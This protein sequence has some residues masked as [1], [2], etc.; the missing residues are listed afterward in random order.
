MASIDGKNIACSRNTAFPAGT[1][2][3]WFFYLD[4]F[5]KTEFEGEMTDLLID[6]SY[7]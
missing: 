2:I 6:R 3:W 5:S 7:P 1:E 4:F